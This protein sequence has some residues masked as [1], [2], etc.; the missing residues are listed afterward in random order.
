MPENSLSGM[1]GRMQQYIGAHAHAT[2]T[3]R[4]GSA[5]PVTPTTA[6]PAPATGSF[7]QL[8][9][10]PPLVVGELT[11]P[12]ATPR[13][14][15]RPAHL[16]PTPQTNRESASTG[17]AGGKSW[18]TDRLRRGAVPGEA[19]GQVERWPRGLRPPASASLRSPARPSETTPRSRL[20]CRMLRHSVS[21]RQR[22]NLA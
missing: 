5:K 3:R 16:A 12:D 2:Q 9:C 6:R 14:D 13:H 21:V 15:R 10:P 11:F 18:R 19:V 22:K 20:C 4:G 8:A 7:P 1:S 17:Q